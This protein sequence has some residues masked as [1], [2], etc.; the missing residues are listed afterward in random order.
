MTTLA[1]DQPSKPQSDESPECPEENKNI[2]LDDDSDC[3]K[4]QHSESD[5]ES[6]ESGYDSDMKLD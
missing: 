6:Q 3:F 1:S 2:Q 5:Q 4:S